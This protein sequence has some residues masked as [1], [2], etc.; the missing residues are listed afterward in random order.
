MGKNWY[1]TPDGWERCTPVDDPDKARRARA[2]SA[3]RVGVDY[4]SSAVDYACMLRTRS[5]HQKGIYAAIRGQYPRMAPR[6]VA[7][8]IRRAIAGMEAQYAF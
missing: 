1:L 6:V 2:N 3:R 5:Y 4:F 7:R 8:V